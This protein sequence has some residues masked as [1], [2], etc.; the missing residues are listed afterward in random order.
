MQK[1]DMPPMRLA[2]EVED[3]LSGYDAEQRPVVALES[4]VLSH[5][6]PFPDNLEAMRGMCAS[7]REAGAIPAVIAVAG[8][9]VVIGADENLL[10]ELARAE[11]VGK[12]N[13]SN[14]ATALARGALGATTVAASLWIAASQGIRVFVTGG[15]GGRHR[16][17][18]RT[19]HDVSSDLHALSRFPVLTVCAGVK[20]ILDVVG[21]RETL[22]TLGVPIIGYRADTLPLFIS[23]PGD[24]P[25]DERI[26]RPELIARVARLHWSLGGA[27]VLATVP[28]PADVA[29]PSNIIEKLLAEIENEMPEEI[30]RDGRR[31]TPWLLRAMDERTDGA[32]RAANIALLL[33]NARVGGQ[34]ATHIAR[35]G[36]EA[37]ISTDRARA[38]REPI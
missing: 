12:I 36:R 19:E 38:Y 20:S 28:C 22:E 10:Q 18:K 25:V 2:S 29:I 24:A 16:P 6:L 14:M 21:T 13:L 4:T 9:Q 23:P 35:A 37:D 34:I 31:A 30:A 7:L 33:N 26:D 32:S 27:G 15:I 3:A 11:S 1:P 5:G 17:S 8:G